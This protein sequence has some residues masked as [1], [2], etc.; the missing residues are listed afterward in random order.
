[1]DLRL[2]GRTEQLDRLDFE[3]VGELPDRVVARGLDLAA[4]DHGNGVPVDAGALGE[5]A[6][7]EQPAPTDGVQAWQV[8][9][10]HARNVSGERYVRAWFLTGKE[11]DAWR[12]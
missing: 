8:S 2:G 3:C 7:G 12:T 1:V 11:G 10:S 6:H 9:V 5:L 4:L